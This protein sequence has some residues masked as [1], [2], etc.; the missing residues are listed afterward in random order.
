MPATGSRSRV[1]PATSS[2]A[3][4]STRTTSV[5]VSRTAPP[6]PCATT[7]WPTTFDTVLTFATATGPST[8]PAMPSARV[9]EQSI[10]PPT[11]APRSAKT[12]RTMCPRRWWWRVLLCGKPPCSTP[13]PRSCAGIPCWCCGACWSAS[14]PPWGGCGLEEPVSIDDHPVDL[15]GRDHL[16]RA[17]DCQDLEGQQAAAGVERWCCGDLDTASHRRC[18]AMLDADRGADRRLIRIEHGC[19]GPHGCRLH[20]GDQPRCAE[21]RDV[22]TAQR[23]GGVGIGDLVTHPAS[24]RPRA[25]AD[26]VVRTCT[27]RLPAPTCAPSP[28]PPRVGWH[29]PHGFRCTCRPAGV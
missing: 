3:I 11:P 27:P 10:S 25:I 1:A 28:T 12:A 14:W 24:L 5:S 15:A 6:R 2:T 7:P 29:R 19:G 20:P 17:V 21:D 26:M 16:P 4:G 13:S 23:R 18:P 8:S 9:G 22:T